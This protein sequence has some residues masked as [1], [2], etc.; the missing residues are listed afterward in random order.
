MALTEELRQIESTL[1][2]GTLG[3]AAR[4]LPTGETVLYNED[5]VFPTASVIK[6]AIVAEL[7]T[8]VA[9]GQL[10]SGHAV[11]VTKEWKAG[12]SG[13]LT[14]LTPGVML[15]LRDL[16]T[17]TIMVSDNTASNLCLGAVGGPEVVNRR[18]RS[19]WGMTSTTIHRPIKFDL[20]PDDPP[21]TAT[22]TP[23]DMMHLCSLLA[24]N[25]VHGES[26]CREVLDRMA[27]VRDTEKLPRY[28]EYNPYAE[29]LHQAR[30][31]LRFYRKTGEVTGVRND[32]GIIRRGEEALAVCVYT[33]GVQ[34]S[35]WTAAHRGSEAVAQVGKLLCE[36]FFR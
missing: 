25:R 3:V 31:P 30:P 8:Q 19:E 27:L 33:K 9:E 15:T 14:A 10:D 11:T 24:E 18:M 7:F 26:V 22:G 4:F 12:G 32:A 34:D 17:L 20:T 29:T 2:E 6:V 36:R 5:T 1:C 21:H 35:R 13:V 28:V 23:Q 16:A